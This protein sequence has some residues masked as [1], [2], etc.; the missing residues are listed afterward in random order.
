MSHVWYREHFSDCGEGGSRRDADLREFD[1]SQRKDSDRNMET[2]KSTHWKGSVFS[3][4][5]NIPDLKWC[6]TCRQGYR[7]PHT[8]SSSA[9]H[10][11]AESP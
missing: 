7:K 11:L 10:S 8:G 6:V 5:I 2:E 1:G 4:G 3:L 9:V